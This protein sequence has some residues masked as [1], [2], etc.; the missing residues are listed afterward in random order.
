MALGC[1]SENAGDL[2]DVL[3]AAALFAGLAKDT[4]A[5]PTGS[6]PTTRSSWRRSAG[7]RRSAS[8]T[9]SGRS[10]SASGPT[11][12]STVGGPDWVPA[13][14]DPALQLV[15]GTDGRS[16]RDV[17]IDGRVVVRDGQCMTVDVD[18][19]REEAAAAGQRLLDRAGIRPR[20]R[21]P[22]VR[23]SDQC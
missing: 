10:R 7:P 17:V 22:L 1:D 18:S 16:V 5:D 12:S 9:R 15:W 21:W 19:L 8:A 2:V 11:S 4:P 23:P 14:R 20:P 13:G 6:A 3:R